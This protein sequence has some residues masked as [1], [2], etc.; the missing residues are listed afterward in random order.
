MLNNWWN[1]QTIE[2]YKKEAERIDKERQQLVI[3]TGE[4]Q[5][6]IIRLNKENKSLKGRINQLEEAMLSSGKTPRDYEFISIKLDN[7]RLQQI[8]EDLKQGRD[9]QRS[10]SSES[11]D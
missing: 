6:N 11:L 8:I 3:T 10:G 1:L 4:L 9:E 7:I 2:D 5:L